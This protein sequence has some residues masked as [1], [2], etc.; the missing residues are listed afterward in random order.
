MLSPSLACDSAKTY[1]IAFV[2][3]PDG[4]SDCPSGDPCPALPLGSD[5]CGDLPGLFGHPT[6]PVTTGRPIGC[7]V[8]LPYGNPYY[9][10]EQ[11]WAIA[12]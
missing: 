7:T 11:E 8:G 6:T 9:A 3:E 4:G 12:S 1:P 10:D 5:T 2:C